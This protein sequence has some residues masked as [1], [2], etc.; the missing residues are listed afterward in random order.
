MGCA[1]TGPPYLDA[2]RARQVAAGAGAWLLT[3]ICFRYVTE[4]KIAQDPNARAAEVDNILDN[5]D[6]PLVRTVP[7][8]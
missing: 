1:S 5:G 8:P 3:V 6:R 2:T 4:R 7:R